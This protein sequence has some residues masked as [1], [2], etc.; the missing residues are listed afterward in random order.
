MPSI[1]SSIPKG[2]QDEHVHAHPPGKGISI[3]NASTSS[4]VGMP[5]SFKKL[6]E[7]LR[8]VR[9]EGALSDHL[10][11]NEIPNDPRWG[12]RDVPGRPASRSASKIRLFYMLQRVELRGEKPEGPADRGARAHATRGA[13]AS[14]GGPWTRAPAPTEGPRARRRPAPPRRARPQAGRRP[15][16]GASWR[17]ARR[18][19]NAPQHARTPE[20]EMT[21]LHSAALPN[22]RSGVH[23]VPRRGVAKNQPPNPSKS[24][25]SW[26]ILDRVRPKC[27]RRLHKPVNFSAFCPLCMFSLSV[28]VFCPL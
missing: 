7:E 12:L 21:W 1:S 11:L 14:P 3:A 5:H 23:V 15:T 18:V 13:A 19:C 22:A 10:Q 8:I 27:V 16:A 24:D 6:G 4:H 25:T 20:P 2:Y 9:G 26:S 17:G 28:C